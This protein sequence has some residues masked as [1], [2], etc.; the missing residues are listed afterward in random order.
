VSFVAIE[1]YLFLETGFHIVPPFFILAPMN[2][3]RLESVSV[4][5]ELSVERVT[6]AIAKP[7]PA[8]AVT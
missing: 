6:N 5:V 7:E 3:V 2:D 8:G 1:M 4:G